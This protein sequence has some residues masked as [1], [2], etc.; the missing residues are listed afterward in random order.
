M[1]PTFAD[2]IL[3]DLLWDIAVKRNMIKEQNIDN[4]EFLVTISRSKI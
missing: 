2:K 1:Q 3:W 4:N